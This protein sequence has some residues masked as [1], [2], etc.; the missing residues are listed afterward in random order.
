MGECCRLRQQLGGLRRRETLTARLEKSA[1]AGFV[2]LLKRAVVPMSTGNVKRWS[3]F[4]TTCIPTKI[5]C[6]NRNSSTVQMYQPGKRIATWSL[7]TLAISCLLIG[8]AIMLTKQPNGAPTAIIEDAELVET[9]ALKCRQHLSG[10][11]FRSSS[12][13]PRFFFWVTPRARS[14]RNKSAQFELTS[15]SR[16]M[17]SSVR[18]AGRPLLRE[19]LDPSSQ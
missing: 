15:P 18:Q 14:A 8:A 2:G 3:G 4:R 5:A 6:R 13:A 10:E 11:A 19:S 17:N 1:T 7:D 16:V 12:A 9:S